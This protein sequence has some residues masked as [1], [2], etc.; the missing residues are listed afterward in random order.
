MGWLYTPDTYQSALVSGESTL[1]L[2]QHSEFAPWVTSK[3]TLS[4]RAFSWRGW[5]NRPWISRLFG[6]ISR[7]SMAQDGVDVWT[8]YLRESHVSLFRMP[9]TG[10]EQMT[11]DGFGLTFIELVRTAG[12]ARSLLRTH[13][14]LSKKDFMKF[15]SILPKWGTMRNGE[16]STQVTHPRPIEDNAYSFWPTTANSTYNHGSNRPALAQSLDTVPWATPT[17]NIWKE[18]GP[19]IDWDLRDQNRITNLAVQAKLWPTPITV[20][21]LGGHRLTGKNKEAKNIGLSLTDASHLHETTQKD[22]QDGSNEDYL[23]PSFVEAMMGMPIG[24]T[25]FGPLEIQ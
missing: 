16:C 6:T 18:T 5:L 8:S 20:D 23:N 24:W 7:P 13:R 10:R 19:N 14:D 11:Q 21:S 25:D 1:D 4:Q 2:K 12:R 17:A 15:S 22:G 9:V 3:G